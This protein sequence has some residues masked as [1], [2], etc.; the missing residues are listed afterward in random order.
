MDKKIIERPKTIDEADAMIF[1]QFIHETVTKGQRGKVYVRTIIESELNKK[2]SSLADKR[3]ILVSDI[4]QE[5]F[6]VYLA[7]GDANE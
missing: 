4:I 5:A 7:K 2:L 3:K 1:S 6:D